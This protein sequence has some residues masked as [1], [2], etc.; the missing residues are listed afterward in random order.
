MTT[1]A[2]P[3]VFLENRP[4][5]IVDLDGTLADATHREQ[6]VQGEKKDWEM[7]YAKCGGDLPI[8]HMLNL[9]QA[10]AQAGGQIMIWT[11][12]PANHWKVTSKWLQQYCQFE[13][14][15]SMRTPGDHRPDYKIKKEWLERLPDSQRNRI[16]MAFEDRDQ[17]VKMYR[18]AGIPCLQVRDGNY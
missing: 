3:S 14:A 1:T 9:I 5:Y 8:M 18:E 4:I 13:Y 16:A 7:F 11:G 15:V 17:M 2:E 6:Y 12:R 10:I